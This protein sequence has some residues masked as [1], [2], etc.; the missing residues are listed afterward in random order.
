MSSRTIQ[1]SLV[2]EFIALTGAPEKVAQRFLK[3]AAWRPDIAADKYG[4]HSFNTIFLLALCGFQITN[5]ACTVDLYIDKPNLK[6][7]GGLHIA[8]CFQRMALKSPTLSSFLVL[9]HLGDDQLAI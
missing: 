9:N 8:S 7:I 2:T 5:R 4:F 1:K 3:A 6:K